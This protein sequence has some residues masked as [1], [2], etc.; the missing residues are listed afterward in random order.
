MAGVILVAMMVKPAPTFDSVA[1]AAFLG[2][3]LFLAPLLALALGPFFYRRIRRG[4]S[5]QAQELRGGGNAK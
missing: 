5:V 2:Q 1:V 4:I 3:F